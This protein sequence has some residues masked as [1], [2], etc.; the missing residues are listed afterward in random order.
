MPLTPE[1]QAAKKHAYYLAN[2]HKWKESYRRN[3]DKDPEKFAVRCAK[4]RAKNRKKLVERQKRYVAANQDKEKARRQA[5]HRRTLDRQRVYRTGYRKRNRERIRARMR[6]YMA[7]RYESDAN[8]KLRSL[9][10]SRVR[11]A[12]RRRKVIKTNRTRELIGCDTDFLRGYLEARF[13][14]GMTWDNQG[15]WHIDHHVPLA[16]FDLREAAQQK[17]AFHYSNLKPMWGPDNM[18]KGAKRPATHQ[19]ELI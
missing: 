12:L 3:Y 6:K 13:L 2:K 15:A 14:P 7:S 4:W 8:F 18:S 17:Q 16:E 1:E 5:Y 11:I 9:L 10:R 19:A